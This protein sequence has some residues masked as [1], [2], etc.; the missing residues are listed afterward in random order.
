MEIEI[1]GIS[2]FL[3]PLYQ[4][5]T[6]APQE[7]FQGHPQTA[8]PLRAS[9][10]PWHRRVPT[11]G[12]AVPGGRPDASPCR[13]CTARESADRARDKGT[14]ADILGNLYGKWEQVNNARDTV[15]RLFSSSVT[16]A[17]QYVI[18]PPASFVSL[19][20]LSYSTSPFPFL[21]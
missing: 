3:R 2:Q 18:A 14:G 11:I 7:A 6:Q 13:Y 10:S 1:Q 12:R 19:Y 4:A 16:Y 21:A 20:H 8:L 15:R 9:R 5:R 17:V